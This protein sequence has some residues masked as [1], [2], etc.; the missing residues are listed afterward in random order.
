MTALSRCRIS[1]RTA[2]AEDCQGVGTVDGGRFG[3]AAPTF[4]EEEGD[5]DI[6][7]DRFHSLVE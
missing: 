7:T 3:L 2:L 1:E 5:E 4:K 6:V